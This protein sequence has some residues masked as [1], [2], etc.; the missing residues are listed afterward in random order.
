MS[1]IK[2]KNTSFE[3]K[4]FQELKKRGLRF[5]TH[6]SQAVGVPDVVIPREKK[7]VFIDSDFW[8]GWRFSKWSS[9][10]SNDF[11]KNKI[12][13]NIKRDAFVTRKLRKH[14]WKVL[15]VWE[16]QLKKN[17]VSTLSKLEKFLRND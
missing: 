6:H 17:R 3:V 11:W 7:A 8:H 10:L 15:R 13:G 4:I 1:A 5:K 12:S 16:H 2:S 14:G 9:S